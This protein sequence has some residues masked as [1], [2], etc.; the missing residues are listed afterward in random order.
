MVEGKDAPRA[1]INGNNSNVDSMLAKLNQRLA[2]LAT[3]VGAQKKPA[4]NDDLSAAQ[5]PARS[6]DM[7]SVTSNHIIALTTAHNTM[8]DIEATLGPKSS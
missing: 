1:T 8:D 2:D 6:S 4:G 5:Q 3:N 7:L